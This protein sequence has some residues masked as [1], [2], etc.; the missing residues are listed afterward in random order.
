MKN[1]HFYIATE[2]QCKKMFVLPTPSQIMLS[3]LE[4]KSW[5]YCIFLDISGSFK[6]YY[7]S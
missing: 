2:I 6:K 5:P 4:K 1:K 3:N 7:S